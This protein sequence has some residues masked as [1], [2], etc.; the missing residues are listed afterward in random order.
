MK[1]AVNLHYSRVLDEQLG[2]IKTNS[3]L[4]AGPS[5]SLPSLSLSIHSCL[6]C[7]SDC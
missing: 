4:A 6:P 5:L 3:L 7:S 2:T 1:G